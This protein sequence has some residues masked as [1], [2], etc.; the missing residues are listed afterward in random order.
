M[1][2]PE[3]LRRLTDWGRGSIE[4]FMRPDGSIDLNS[5]EARAHFHLIKKVEMLGVDENGFPRVKLELHDAKD[6]VVHIAKIHG[7]FVDR[8]EHS[9]ELSG[10]LKIPQ[11]ESSA[12]WAA[13]AKSQQSALPSASIPQPLLLKGDSGENN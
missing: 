7:M 4:H 5:E 6:A 11:L 3:A 8:V 12:D 2:V 13:R 1:S 10:V 9:G